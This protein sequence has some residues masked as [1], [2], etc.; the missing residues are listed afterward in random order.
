[1]IGAHAAESQGSA[2]HAVNP[3][4]GAKLDPAFFSATTDEIDRAANL[5]ADAFEQLAGCSG[6]DRARYCEPS[7]T[8]S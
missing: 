5:A 1:L 6:L 2:F 3:A 7:L 4:T 8:S